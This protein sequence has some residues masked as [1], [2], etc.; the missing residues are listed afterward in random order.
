[1]LQTKL[2]TR[3][4]IAKY[5]QLAKTKFNDKIDESIIEAQITD[6]A[7][8]IGEALFNDLLTN[9][10]AHSELLDGGSYTVNGVTFENYGLKACLSHYAYARYQ[11]FGDQVQTP[12]GN[13]QK[14]NSESKVVDYPIRKATY[15]K[16]CQTAF[17]IWENVK[18]FLIRKKYPKFIA[19][20]CRKGYTPGL[21]I[22]KIK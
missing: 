19:D 1:M 6:V 21:K 17:N 13:V 4:D 3:D 14:L 2:I 20:N 12:F 7:P 11:M 15:T 16:D 8:L 9:T 22:Y 5:K 18:L 10:A